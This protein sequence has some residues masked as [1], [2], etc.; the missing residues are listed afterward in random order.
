MISRGPWES[1]YGPDDL[2][3][4]EVIIAIMRAISIHKLTYGMLV[5]A[6]T[7]KGLE[8]VPQEFRKGKCQKFQ[9]L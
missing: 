5:V 4:I 3:K 9:T 2:G 7:C 6:F 8:A 1:C